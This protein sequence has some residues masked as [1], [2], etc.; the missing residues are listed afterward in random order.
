MEAGIEFKKGM[1]RMKDGLINMKNTCKRH[2]EGYFLEEQ[3]K[4]ILRRQNIWDMKEKRGI[5]CLEVYV[6][7]KKED[8]E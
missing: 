8:K 2:M 4:Y 3:L 1:G 5:L 7:R 6:E